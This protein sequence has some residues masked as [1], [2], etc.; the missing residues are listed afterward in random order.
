MCYGG[1]TQA[2]QNS[3]VP[4]VHESK[5]GLAMGHTWSAAAST[6]GSDQTR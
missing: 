2:L 1:V 6:T 5:S 4:R 3:T